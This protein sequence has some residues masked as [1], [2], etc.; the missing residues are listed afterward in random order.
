M[1]GWQLANPQMKDKIEV[2]AGRRPN[3]TKAIEV[4]QSVGSVLK[5]YP[6]VANQ[7]ADWDKYQG[8]SF[9]VKGD[10]SDGWAQITFGYRFSNWSYTFGFPVD[11]KEWKQYTVNFAD[12]AFG[13]GYG[14]CTQL[15]N[16]PGVRLPMGGVNVMTIGN[17]RGLDYNNTRPRRQFTYCIADVELVEKAPPLFE[18]GKYKPLPLS[19]FAEKLKNGKEI[20]ISAFGD[21]ITVGNGLTDAGKERYIERLE[22][23]LREHFKRENINAT[24]YAV[25]GTCIPH[26]IMWID[27]DIKQPPDLITIL[28][29]YNHKPDDPATFKA[30]MSVWLDRVIAKTKG[31]STIL[32]IASIPGRDARFDM[33]T[34]RTLS[35][36]L[37]PNAASPSAMWTRNS[38]RSAGRTTPTTCTTSRTPTPRGTRR[39]RIRWRRS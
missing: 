22:S 37:P 19:A 33:L 5:D 28:F 9:W 10:G 4:S 27:R 38:R 23:K 31:Q 2:F 24:S 34:T 18:I 36:S 11:N 39:S 16:S 26:T 1:S 8:I 12:F 7:R 21:S 6:I 30:Q 17:D 3:G 15:F 35:A 29:G 20:V 32:L 14:N 25:G 13:S